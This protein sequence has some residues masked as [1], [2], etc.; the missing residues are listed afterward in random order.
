MK[1]SAGVLHLSLGVLLG[2]AAAAPPEA[3]AE[4]RA[5]SKRSLGS[6]VN[7]V[8]GGSC[9]KGRCRISGGQRAG[10]NLFHRFR[11]FDTRGAIRD[12][13]FQTGKAKNLFVGVTS[14]LGSFIDKRIALSSK[15]NLFWLSPGGMVLGSGADFVNTPQL[16][17]STAGKLNFDAGQFDVFSSSADDL[18]LL[19]GEPLPGALGLQATPQLESDAGLLPGIHLNGINISIDDDLLIDAPGGQVAV[20]NSTLSVSA[21]EGVGGTL[22]L[23]G[24][25]IEI[26]GNSQFLATGPEGGG[27]IQ[28]GG[29]WQNSDPSVRQSVKATVES[30]AV[31]DASATDIGNGGEIVVWSDITNPDAVTS[32]AGSLSVEAGIAGGDGGRIETSGADL[33]IAGVDVSTFS[34][35]G[36]NGLWLLDPTDYIIGED[37][38][39]A[40]G[41]ALEGGNNVT[42]LVS[43]GNCDASYATSSCTVGTPSGGGLT[44]AAGGGGDDRIKIDR[45]INAS[46]SA[47]VTLTLEAP[48][49]VVLDDY[50]SIKTYGSGSSE[51]QAT[52]KIKSSAGGLTGSVGSSIYANHIIVDQGGDSDFGGNFY[53]EGSS[54]TNP[55]GSFTKEGGGTLT[56]SSSVGNSDY[57]S[58]GRIYLNGGTL[59]ANTANFFAGSSNTP[60]K[61][62][63]G[64][65]KYG[66]SLPTPLP[67]FSSRF[68][69][70]SGQIFKI[71]TNTATVQFDSPIQGS[72]NSLV[73]LGSGTLNLSATNNTYDGTTTVDAGVLELSHSINNSA[74]SISSGATLKASADP[75]EVRSISGEGSIFIPSGGRLSSDFDNGSAIFSGAISGSGIFEKIGSGILTLSGVSSFTGNTTVEGGELIISDEDGIGSGDVSV[76]DGATL[77][78]LSNKSVPSNFLFEN[79]ILLGSSVASPVGATLKISQGSAQISRPIKVLN[80]SIISLPS[81]GSEL[82]LDNTSQTSS[83]VLLAT[84]LTI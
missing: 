23:T 13:R 59:E 8:K 20:E 25:Q 51:S 64:I 62:N 79:N 68:L 66:S 80:D 5:S 65:L 19:R 56:V 67:D 1:S 50:I 27:L 34:P 46:T 54:S 31:L 24:E 33:D 40:I 70:D 78:I 73:K 72:G 2:F 81:S 57:T 69:S 63:G 22:M 47:A 12:V 21:E 29:S 15:A 55:P 42:V 61:F 32:V 11:D 10:K 75:S 4:I 43:G 28:V 17:L 3:Q 82:L 48:G 60:F 53:L 14:P 76:L 36:E 49:G 6:K 7:G 52:V 84:S 38:A 45:F 83:L 18:A 26:D 77:S 41:S 30:G 16:R 35:T 37:A 71:D 74:V 39:T 58:N 44:T 9:N